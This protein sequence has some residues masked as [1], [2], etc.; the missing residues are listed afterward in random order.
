[1]MYMSGLMHEE[2]ESSFASW[3]EEPAE[4]E[5]AV[6]TWAFARVHTMWRRTP[7]SMIVQK[8]KA[9]AGRSESDIETATRLLSLLATSVRED[10]I[11]VIRHT[12]NDNTYENALKVEIAVDRLIDDLEGRPWRL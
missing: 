2:D 6:P 7:P 5:S 9:A 10:R 12:L 11:R 4:V 1:M 8:S 3:N